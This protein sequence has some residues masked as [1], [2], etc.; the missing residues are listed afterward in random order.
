LPELE[1]GN[2]LVPM[3]GFRVQGGAYEYR[4]GSSIVFISNLTLVLKLLKI[5]LSTFFNQL[6]KKGMFRRLNNGADQITPTSAL[7][8]RKVSLHLHI[9]L[10]VRGEDPMSSSS[11]RRMSLRRVNSSSSSSFLLCISSKFLSSCRSPDKSRIRCS[12]LLI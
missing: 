9:E 6:E 7:K 5:Y 2:V 4:R 12:K 10:V 8:S 1:P 3:T 11:A